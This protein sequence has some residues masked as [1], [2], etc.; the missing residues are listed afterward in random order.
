MEFKDYCVIV[1]GD[2]D[3]AKEEISR[4]SESDVRFAESKGVLMA[5][6]YT[7][8]T[9][10]ELKTYLE[11][12]N[13]NFFLFEMGDDNYGVNLNDEVIYNHL[14]EPNE[15]LARY[16]LISNPLKNM[17]NSISGTTDQYIENIDNMS[18][19]ECDKLLDKLLDKG[20]ENWSN[21]DKI[22]IEKLT[23]KN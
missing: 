6:F 3:G 2:V 14:F 11:S 5:T 1:L 16:T 18:K 21:T 23:K 8:A 22:I 13:R 7:V 10:P 12:Y 9:A 20:V 17:N 19:S 4:I 15:D